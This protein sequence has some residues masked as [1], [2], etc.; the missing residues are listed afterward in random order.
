MSW[1]FRPRHARRRDRYWNRNRPA[2][3]E[4]DTG[5]ESESDT[6]SDLLCSYPCTIH[7]SE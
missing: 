1:E 6:D 7:H 4:V 3:V 2:I 5:S